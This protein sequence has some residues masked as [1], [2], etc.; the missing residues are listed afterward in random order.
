MISSV[1]SPILIAFSSIASADEDNRIRDIAGSYFLVL[2]GLA[3]AWFAHALSRY[4]KDNR[5]ALLITGSAAAGG[6]IVAAVAWG[7]VP[8]SL[9]F[10]SLVDDP[11]LQEGQAVL[12]QFGYVALG[13]GGMLPAA[14]FIALVASTP[15]LVPRWL[16]IASY[17]IAALVA[18]TA[19]LF[20]PI[21]LFV[22]WVIAVAA[23]H[24][25]RQG[26]P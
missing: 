24:R 16:S 18:F 2:A 1:R 13:L 3:F 21:L 25:R 22:L 12:P 20:M 17:P 9:W 5:A 26:D 14:A 8:M 6:M 19:L 11:G 4:A 23:S 15:G 10:G 7:A